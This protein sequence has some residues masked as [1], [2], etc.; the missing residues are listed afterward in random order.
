MR[1]HRKLLGFTAV[2]FLTAIGIVFV[3]MSIMLP[4]IVRAR[5]AARLTQCFNQL[6]QISLALHNYHEAQSTFPPGYISIMGVEDSQ[7]TNEWAWGAF[8]LPYIDQQPLFEQIDFNYSVTGIYMDSNDVPTTNTGG[9]TKNAT[10]SQTILST[11]LCPLDESA[12]GSQSSPAWGLPS[13]S[14]SAV[15]GI[16][17]MSFPCATIPPEKGDTQGDSAL[18]SCRP[19]EGAFFLNSRIRIHDVRDGLSQTMFIAETSSRADFPVNALADTRHENTRFWGG[20]YWASVVNPFAQ[21]RVLTAT[22]SGISPLE[23]THF[24]P[25][26]SSGHLDGICAAFGDGSVHLISYKVES[27]SERPYGVLQK[28][29]TIS[30]SDLVGEF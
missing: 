24:S 27:N 22:A 6:K 26:L 14:Y 30:D 9:T 21:D 18:K 11:Y 17:W 4:A 5:N 10:S 12:I 20:T 7:L 13:A 8:L 3:L 29:S 19:T 2:E 25:G 15:T 1:V 28:L 23:E 16:H